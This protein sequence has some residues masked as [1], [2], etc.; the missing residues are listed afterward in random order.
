MDHN[1]RSGKE[2]IKTQS[3][4]FPMER[5]GAHGFTVWSVGGRVGGYVDVTVRAGA[6]RQE[7]TCQIN[8]VFSLK[9]VESV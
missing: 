1:P 4:G 2:G 3:K 6:G 8:T 5:S 7:H 9:Q